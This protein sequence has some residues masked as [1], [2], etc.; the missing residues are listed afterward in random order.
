MGLRSVSEVEMP[1]ID[2]YLEFW[3]YLRFQGLKTIHVIDNA[4]A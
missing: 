1:K 3:E 4:D 2:V